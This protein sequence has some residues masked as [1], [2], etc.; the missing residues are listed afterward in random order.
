MPSPWRPRGNPKRQH[1]MNKTNTQGRAYESRGDYER[2]QAAIRQARPKP[3]PDKLPE[4]IVARRQ[5]LYG[6]R[7]C[8][9]GD[10]IL[11][12]PAHPPKA[13]GFISESDARAVLDALDAEKASPEAVAAFLAA[14]DG[15]GGEV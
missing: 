7:L 10:L 14:N 3:G 2:A 4:A 5:A 1:I 11:I 8:Q 9:P 15:E 6:G 13:S 12:W